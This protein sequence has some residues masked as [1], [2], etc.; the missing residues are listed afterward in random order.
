MNA[1]RRINAYSGLLFLSISL[2]ASTALHAQAPAAGTAVSVKM[3]DT[4]N[5][6]GD[7]AGKQYRASVAK[8]ITAAN[9]IAIPQGSAATVTLTRSGS[10]YAAQL[11]SITINGQVVGVTSNSPTVSAVAQYA[12]DKAASAVG[13]VLGGLG[14][15]VSA[16]ATVAAA[17]TGQHVSLPTGTTLT[18]VLGQP[19]AMSAGATGSPSP[20]AGQP[21]IASAVPASAAPAG[22]AAAAAPGQNWW[23]C[24]YRDMKDPY[25]PAAGSFMYYALVPASEAVA[26]GT[27]GLNDHFAAYVRQNYKVNDNAT[28]GAVGAGGCQRFSND[29]ATR[30]NSLDMSQK[31]WASSNIESIHVNWTNTPAE[32]A[33][34]DAKLAAAASVAATAAATPTAAANQNYVW[35]NSAWGGTAGTMMP[36]GTMMYFSDV[37]PAD[38]PPPPTATPGHPLPPNANGAQINRIYALQTSFFTFLQKKYGYKDSG[39]YPVDCRTGYPPTVAGLQNAQKYRQQFEDLA[40][41]NRG[42]IVET[43]WKGK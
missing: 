27:H 43:G 6:A 7:P 2:L 19:P 11:S 28:A 40:K 23:M 5:S 26:N 10:D 20:P 4:V 12:Q 17:A 29:P 41:Q 34:I 9:G 14:H 13:S 25:K 8:A 38:M 36:A 3:I 16:P 30:A 33:T 22:P 31:Q 39:N 32:N 42:Q 35:C 1:M 37:F 24:S 21:A 15:H 18:F